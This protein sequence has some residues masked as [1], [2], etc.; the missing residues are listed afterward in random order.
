[1]LPLP[2]TRRAWLLGGAC[3][4]A[5]VSIWTSFILIARVS[6]A[7]S[8]SPFDIAFLRFVFSAGLALPFVWRRRHALRAA[9]SVDGGSPWLRMAAIAGFAG[10][11]YCS[12]AYSAFFFAP[13]AH[14]A[15]LLP[16]SLP[17]WTA[18]LAWACLGERVPRQRAVG[19]ALIVLGDVLVGGA[20][21]LLAFNGTQ[22]WKGDL[23]FMGASMCWASYTLLCRHW[24]LGAIDA[25]FT[26]VV[27]CV[28]TYVP[29]Y[30]LGVASGLVPSRLGQ[31]PWAEIGFQAAYQGGLA[32]LAA[33][34]AFTQ[35]VATFGPARTTMFTALVPA[36]AALL[37]VPLLGEALAPNAVAGLLCVTLGL[38]FGLRS[39]VKP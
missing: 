22:V 4:V 10:V 13:V 3:A 14:G 39:Q 2:P 16:G 5:V 33:G 36:L 23:L 20:S 32:M 7:H 27:G 37:A 9:L 17:L 25:T 18:F 38:A 29:L 24:R 28:C 11:G 15:V 31:A 1:M 8:L 12:L 35:V 21:L 19:L 6:A 26:I 34:L 30:A